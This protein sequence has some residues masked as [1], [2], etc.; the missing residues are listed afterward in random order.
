MGIGAGR[1]IGQSIARSCSDD[2]PLATSIRAIHERPVRTGDRRPTGERRGFR[3]PEP[4]PERLVRFAVGIGLVLLAMTAASLVAR[5]APA[6]LR[7]LRLPTFVRKVTLVNESGL[8]LDIAVRGRNASGWLDLGSV[9]P[10][11]SLAVSEVVDQGELWIVRFT[12][13]HAVY[14]ELRVAR[15][16]LRSA[17]WR[18][19]ITADAIESLQTLPQSEDGPSSQTRVANEDRQPIAPP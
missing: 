17:H 5:A 12:H 13:R 18:I 4:R 8:D 1:A 15:T 16:Q 7:P 3:I 9:G 19:V 10:R 2:L 11:S 6:L 14:G